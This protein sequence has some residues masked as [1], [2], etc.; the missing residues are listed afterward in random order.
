MLERQKNVLRL[1]KNINQICSCKDELQIASTYSIEDKSGDYTVNT[2]K[3][4]QQTQLNHCAFLLQ[5]SQVVKQFLIYYR[6]GLLPRDKI[7]SVFNEVQL[8]QAITLFKLFYYA[9]DWDTFYKT[10]VWARNHVNAGMFVYALSVALVHRT[11]TYGIMVPPIYEVL[12]MAFFSSEVVQEAEVFKQ[13]LK[14]SGEMQKYTIVSNYSGHY[15]NLHPE[16]SMSYYTEDIG[17]NA[18]YYYCNVYYP[19]WMDGKY[20]TRING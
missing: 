6:Q 18:F 17:L 13:K 11:D 1:F 12:P 10:A 5:N 9:K 7:F 8:K 20:A 14:E 15:L 16:Q 19:F 3:K 2:D 4:I